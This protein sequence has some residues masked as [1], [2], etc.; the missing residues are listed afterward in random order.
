MSKYDHGTGRGIRGCL[1]FSLAAFISLVTVGSVSAAPLNDGYANRLPIQLGVAD[2]RSNVGA[3]IEPGET[4]TSNDPNAFGCDKQGGAA[5]GGFQMNGTLWWEFTGTGG[6]ITVSTL[7]SNF[8]TVLGLYEVN[9]GAM[10]RC[11]DDLQA[12]DPTRPTLQYRLASE[13]L[14]DSV[15]GRQYAVQVGGCIPAEKCGTSTSGNITL[16]VSEPPPNDHRAAAMPIVAGGPIA[17]SN[18]GATTEPGE[19]MICGDHLYGKTV[20]FRFTA[21]AIGTAA[22][23]AAGF[24]TILAVYRASS[25][26]PLGCNDDAVEGQF[27]GS[28]LPTSLPPGPPLEL[29]PGEYLLQVGGFF[30]NGFTPVAARN[31]PLSIQVEFTPDTD[32]DNDGVST[33]RDCD[34]SNAAIRPGVPEVPNNDVDE[35]CDGFKAFDR[36]GDGVLAPPLGRDCRDDDRKISPIATEIRGNRTDE[37][38]DT[39]TPDYRPLPTKIG[40]VVRQYPKADP[41]SWIK[42]FSLSHVPAGVRVEIRCTGNSC[43]Y[44]V[45]QYRVKQDR[46][47]L[48][49]TAGFRLEVGDLLDLR[50]TKEDAIGREQIFRMRRT[51]K[52]ASRTYCLDPAGHRRA[53]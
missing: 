10:V 32:L 31:G 22:F 28:R 18:T 15:A 49:L 52:P 37:N 8:D 6:P 20:W 29:T 34:E 13:V 44:P 42:A 41:H 39:K 50:V 3:T 16:R 46:G 40:L 19:T 30:D 21:P 25:S 5:T 33:E 36:D 11:N 47:T 38:C 45:R 27:G 35:D 23:S 17:V 43:P 1:A 9:G 4:L 14:F 51:R 7:S 53:C 24:D 26:T 48:E 2:T 12:Q